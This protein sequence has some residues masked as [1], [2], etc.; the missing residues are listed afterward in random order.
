MHRRRAMDSTLVECSYFGGRREPPTGM[1]EF[2]VTV[3]P[4]EEPAVRAELEAKAAAFVKREVYFYDTKDTALA[5]QDLFL[6]GRATGGKAPDS[7]VKLR[8]VPKSGIPA[9]WKGTGY[10]DEVDMVGNTPISSL[11]LDRPKGEID[12]SD[13]DTAPRKLFDKAQEGVVPDLWGDIKVLGPI[14]AHV[15]E[16]EYGT[17]PKKLSVEEWTVSGG[18]H[19]IE[20][21]FK[22]EAADEDA[23]RE[24]FHA[25]LDR[26]GIGHDGDPA[27][28]TKRVIEFLAD[29]LP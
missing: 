20:L 8:P 29:R 23:A 9:A 19:F 11:K 26:L 17:V 21:S 12:E 10:R 15:W 2:K 27:P 1:I 22:V 25:L 14:H 6:R 7:T 13:L 18:P 28:K 3:H 5:D 4:H 24:G 16:L